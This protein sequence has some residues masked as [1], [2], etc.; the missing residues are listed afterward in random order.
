MLRSVLLHT[1]AV[2]VALGVAVVLAKLFGIESQWVVGA[3]GFLMIALE[4]L[5][6]AWD[7]VPISDWVNNER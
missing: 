2:A 3:L 7:K 1:L 6:R 5:V 4:K